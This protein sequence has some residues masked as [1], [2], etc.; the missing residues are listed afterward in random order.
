M[1]ICFLISLIVFS[2]TIISA[3]DMLFGV[4]SMEKLSET[5]SDC[6]EENN[7]FPPVSLIVPACNEEANIAQAMQS[8]L[9]QD[10]PN[11]EIVA[12]NDRSTDRTG[13]IL[14]EFAQTT[15]KLKVL[16][17]DHLP[18]GWMGKTNALQQGAAM[19]SGEYLLFTD[20]DIIMVGQTVKKAAVY[21]QHNRLGHLCLVFKNI[22]PG[23]MLNALILD[24]GAGLIQLVRP[25]RA[26]KKGSGAF[27]GVGAFNMVRRDV[28]ES[29]GG[30]AKIKMH[31]IDDIMLGKTIKRA[32]FSQECM[33]GMDMVR[34]PWYGSVSDMIEGLMKNVLALVNYRMIFVPL[35][36][37]A[38][39]VFAILPLWGALFC[40]GTAQLLFAATLLIR[41]S[42]FTVGARILEIPITCGFGTLLSPYITC[43]ILVKAT[44]KNLHDGGIYWRGT[45]YALSE[46]RENESIFP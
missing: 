8:L 39:F 24:A 18:P 27:I 44:W 3:L 13:E 43:Y 41:L 11:L 17:L 30:H 20:G 40:G 9:Q 26:S 38:I 46:L 23:W 10:Y 15:A 12:V 6:I 34:V 21:M 25:W 45:H 28:Y 19:A 1:D 4:T 32:G 14:D 36:L 22:S 37:T 31:P 5:K 29:I 35:L 2:A 16:H 33:L 42:E 7:D